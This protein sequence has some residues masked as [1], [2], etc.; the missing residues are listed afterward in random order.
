MRLLVTDD[1]ESLAR[2]AAS[3][4]WARF[5]ETPSATLLFP[6]GRTPAPLYER[7]ASEGAA[8][9]IDLSA[10]TLFDLDEYVGVSPG[11]DGSFARQLRTELADRPPFRSAT[12]DFFDGTA[13]G[14]AECARREFALRSA[15]GA[16]LAILGLGTDGHLAFNAPG[17]RF[18]TRTR[19]VDLPESMRASFRGEG[20]APTR[21]LTVGLATILD[22]KRILLLATG[23]SKAPA[24]AAA[25]EGRVDEGVPGS[26]LQ[27][28]PD[29]TVVADRAAASCLRRTGRARQE[30]PELRVYGSSDLPEE[31]RIVVVSPHP[32]DASIG[33]GGLISMLGP[34]RQVT[35]LGFTSGHRARIDGTSSPQERIRIRRRELE[36]ECRI[37]GA[38]L[39][40]L[41]LSF[42]DEGYAF[43]STDVER[44][45][46][47]LL[48]LEPDWIL[49]PSLVDRHPAHRASTHLALEALRR[50][51]E[52]GRRTD[53]VEIWHYE[54]P[55][56]LFQPD[57]V[58]AIVSLP[59]RAVATKQ[60]AIAQHVSQMTRHRYDEAAVALARYRAVTLPESR[61]GGF[62][63]AG[64]DV[65]E[66]IE[67]FQR[68]V[69]SPS[70]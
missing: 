30:R 24:L 20:P 41:D 66:S 55:W 13:D 22:A 48:E 51:L 38:E 42:Y 65:G 52:T 43:S 34:R 53:P 70:S 14:E 28:H 49:A 3:L 39:R 32:D 36:E 68:V 69:F 35:V 16:D 47:T 57:D 56:H 37:L 15:G 62:G 29:V 19:L 27:I 58:N 54:G 4:V 46:Q 10:S 45:T 5:V 25:L 8:L 61:L 44:V 23:E 17:T 31:I 59:S 1:P 26:I 40:R 60:A 33:C 11:Q 21:G 6:G 63:S 9:G 7:L 18:G 12:I 2:I 64:G 50:L 67:V